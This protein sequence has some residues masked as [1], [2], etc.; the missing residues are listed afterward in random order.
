LYTD[1]NGLNSM[2]L[3]RKTINDINNKEI[4]NYHDLSIKIYTSKENIQ[5]IKQNKL[6]TI[7]Q[8]SNIINE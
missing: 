8:E 5:K 3:I 1:Q 6:K 2:E 7:Y 4:K